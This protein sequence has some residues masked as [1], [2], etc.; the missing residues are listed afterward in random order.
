MAGR[1]LDAL[2]SPLPE[3]AQPPAP[4]PTIVAVPQPGGGEGKMASIDAAGVEPAQLP[5]N[6]AGLKKVLAQTFGDCARRR[7]SD[8]PYGGVRV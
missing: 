8:M 2:I 7:N 6:S 4:P 5:L 3:Q 1:G